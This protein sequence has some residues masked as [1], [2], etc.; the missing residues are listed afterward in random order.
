M[1]LDLSRMS[2]DELKAH[3]REVQAAI[4]SFEERKR[5]EALAEVEALAKSL[6]FP[7]KDLV[8]AERATRG[9]K[10]GT[11]SASRAVFANPQNP[12]QTWSGRGRRP[13]WFTAALEAGK[14]A[15]DLKI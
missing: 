6:G 1:S 8:G 5:K 9:R 4:S 11:A 13:G 2:L 10:G 15:D 12:S 7:L 3:L 14:S